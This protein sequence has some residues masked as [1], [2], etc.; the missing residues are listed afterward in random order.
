MRHPLCLAPHRKHV[1]GQM[2]FMVLL[3]AVRSKEG[4]NVTPRALDSIC[5]IPG[6]R[7]NER[8]RII[9][10]AVGVTVG[11]DI[12]IRSP[13][14]ADERG[15]GFD[16]STNN[17]RQCVGDSVRNGNKKCSTGLA[18]HTAKHPLVL[19]RVSPMVFTP[20]EL[21]LINLNGPVRTAELLRAALQ[22]YQQC[23]PAEHSPVRDRVITEVMFAL[24][25]VGRFAAQ[26]VVREVQNLLEGEI[27]PVEPR[28]VPYGPRSRAPGSSYH[29]TC[30]QAAPSV[31]YTTSCKHSLVLLRM[32]EI[33]ARNML[34]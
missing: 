29:P 22:V 27:T 32:G 8:D 4:L 12:L 20:T 11:P 34:S 25:L 15:A 6:V 18:L 10:R 19:Y 30:L 24:D 13:A 17:T 26:D 33:I 21:A 23:L 16:P 7:M 28:P 1:V 5:V 9:H 14:I 3:P 31:H 2:E